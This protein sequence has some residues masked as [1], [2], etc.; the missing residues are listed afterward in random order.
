[1][2]DVVKKF[3]RAKPQAQI[4]PQENL[5][6]LDV[7]ANE[8][9]SI[10]TRL[11][12]IAYQRIEEKV[13]KQRLKVVSK[14]KAELLSI[15]NSVIDNEIETDIADEPTGSSRFDFDDNE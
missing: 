7:L 5:S 3:V 14:A 4:T 13:L 9:S 2:T 6:L 1:M 15:E 11:E 10:A 8:E 12:T